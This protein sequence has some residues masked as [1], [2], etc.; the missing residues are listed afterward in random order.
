M[1]VVPALAVVHDRIAD[2]GGDPAAVRVVAVTKGFGPDAVAAARAAGL[3]DLGE[4]Y[5]GELTAKHDGTPTWHHLGSVQR[6]AVRDLAPLVDVW[7]GVDRLEE[8]AAIAGQRP[9]ARVLVQVNSAGD[10]RAGVLPAAAAPLVDGL[11]E[12]GLDVLGLMTVAPPGGGDAARRAFG[13]VRDLAVALGLREC[14]MGMT[15][16]LEAAVREGTTMVRIGTALF[17]PRPAPADLRR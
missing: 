7:Q 2:A 14:S 6:R 15:G 1:N 3:T 9:G 4:N 16:D 13:V 17:G 8:G 5:A 11:R 12:L 10:D